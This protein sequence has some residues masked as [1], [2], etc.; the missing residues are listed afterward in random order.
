M[1]GFNCN[2]KLNI[3]L[4]PKKDKELFGYIRKNSTFA[5]D[6]EN[7]SNNNK[8]LGST[9]KPIN[10]KTITSIKNYKSSIEVFYTENGKNGNINFHSGNYL[11][12]DELPT[13]SEEKKYLAD[14]YDFNDESLKVLLD[15]MDVNEWIRTK[16]I[17]S[18]SEVINEVRNGNHVNMIDMLNTYE[19][20]ASSNGML[21][22]AITLVEKKHAR[23]HA[24]DEV[25][26]VG[27]KEVNITELA[28]I[29]D[30]MRGK[31]DAYI[32]IGRKVF[33][34]EIVD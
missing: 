19:Y 31:G 34:G 22:L 4:K 2:Q 20:A 11:L 21:S 9:V 5:L 3:R 32:V 25:V 26:T 30:S 24:D 23:L 14:E 12:R 7:N 33:F 6:K 28:N 17:V 8:A 16:N 10:M 13:R 29:M 15:M 27:D 1:G 18:I